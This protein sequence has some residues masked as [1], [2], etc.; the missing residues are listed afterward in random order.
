MGAGGGPPFMTG[1]LTSALVVL[2]IGLL[3]FV[4]ELGHFLVAKKVGIRVEAFSMGFGPMLWGFTRGGTVYK[5][6]AIPL[7]GYVKMAG[8]LP[9]EVTTDSRGDE[10]FAKSISQRAWV[11][12]AGVI[13]NVLLAFVLFPIAFSI[14]VRRFVERS[15]RDRSRTEG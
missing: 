6:C 14:G 1:L 15:R 12:S 10:F 3:I 9:G 7:G 11:V 4:H 13:M 5:I 8:E 2:A